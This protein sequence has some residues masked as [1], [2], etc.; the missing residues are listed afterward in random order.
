MPVGGRRGFS[1]IEMLVVVA[2]MAAIAALA[3][4]SLEGW[5]ESERVNQSVAQ[6]EAGVA[7]GRARARE[8]GKP[9]EV[10]LVADGAVTAPRE[11][12]DTESAPKVA[13]VDVPLSDGLR[14]E[15]STGRKGDEESHATRAEPKADERIGGA[16]VL[17]VCLPDGTVESEGAMALV[18]KRRT[19]DLTVSRWT[20]AVRGADR[21]A[22]GSDRKTPAANPGVGKAGAP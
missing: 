2:V 13:G 5:S 11:S 9:V 17:A 10:R 6:I 21:P 7:A 1:M 8:S 15:R 3:F 20:G 22:P 14:A 19:I 4:P 12:A 16:L 18:T